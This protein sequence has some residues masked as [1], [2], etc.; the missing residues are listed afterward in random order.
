MQSPGVDIVGP[1]PDKLQQITI[2][3][4]GVFTG[5]AQIDA[6]NAFVAFLASP[7]QAA[8]IRANGME[9]L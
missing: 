2:F 3:T 1:L 6:A 7:A 9:P 8:L 5:S 4:G